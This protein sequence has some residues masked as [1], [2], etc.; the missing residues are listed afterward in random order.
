MFNSKFQ[1]LN[2]AGLI[3]RLPVF[4]RVPR[5]HLFDDQLSWEIPESEDT[6][7]NSSPTEPMFHSR[8]KSSVDDTKI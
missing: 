5:D 2:V 7:S 8:N 3:L 1:W 6:P 4:G